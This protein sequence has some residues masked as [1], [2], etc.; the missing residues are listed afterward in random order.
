MHPNAGNVQVDFAAA[1]RSDIPYL[2][3][4]ARLAGAIDA[5]R[6]NILARQ[7][8]AGFWHYELEADCTI[9]AEYIL[10]L[11]YLGESEPRLQAKL[12]AY[13]RK[14]QDQSGGWPLYPG[15]AMELSCS[16][17]AYFALKL[18]G[19][20]PDA[21]HMQRAR[22]VIL[23]RGG[24]VRVNVFTRIALA[25]Y[26]ELP[27]RGVPFVPVEIMLLP[28][29]FPFHLLK[30]S[31]WSRTVMVP[32]MVLTSLKPRAKNPT[33]VH[34]RELFT[35]PPEQE[36]H[37]FPVRSPLNR[38][39]LAVDAISRRLEFLIPHWLRKRALHR[40]EQWII[41][42]LNSDGGLGAIFPAMVNAYEALEL[43][44][45]PADHPYRLETRRA[46]CDLLVERDQDAY[47]QPCVSPVWD[48]GLICLAL[49]EDGAAP[50]GVLPHALDWLREQ[51]LLD[52]PGDWRETH[53]HLPGGGWAFQFC[54]DAYP[55]LDDTAVVARAMH[56]APDRHDY[57]E[58][59]AR[60]ADWLVGMQS[61]NGGFAAFD[62]D[63]DH[64]YL[65]QIPFADH[66]ALL[67]P[68][69]SDVTAR[70]VTLL[71]CLKRPQDQP[72]RDRAL[73]FLRREQQ[74]S[75]A[76]FGRWG[77]NY[78]YGTW[79]VLAALSAAGVSTQAP[80]IRRAAA[81]L[82]S[83]QKPDGGWGETN[84][85]YLDPKLAG[86]GPRST[87]CQTA[88]ALLGLMAAGEAENTAVARGVEYLLR[89]Q[90]DGGWYDPEFNA[91]GF[92]RVFYLKY[93]GYSQ[94]FPFWALARYRNVTANGGR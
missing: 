54:N 12:T 80:V 10:M 64:A 5:A 43:L 76:W 19:D 24:A 48:T 13:L 85:D 11:H 14:H 4:D 50:P 58:A 56:Q 84:D 78:I 63:N 65:N 67:D 36:Q 82:L 30:V 31:Y 2:T 91:P 87:A 27:W 47:C 38:V 29:W 8:S 66:G 46:I 51:Q 72:A 55:D 89:T 52:A 20:S 68:S 17:K 6:E 75:G 49:E 21:T 42:R 28:R 74:E 90:Q 37:Y 83:R 18:A 69:T 7:D 15:G 88:W 34:I 41:A 73:A 92:P 81:W 45:Y 44:G 1:R 3:D 86:C 71:S 39:F 33:G 79:S 35:T 61:R 57:R 94:Y 40:A 93:H 53:P 60:A 62:S 22:E 25:L 26:G 16:V 77:T 70:V 59:I 23:A 9:P 32:L